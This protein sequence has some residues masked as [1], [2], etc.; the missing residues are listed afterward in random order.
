MQFDSLESFFYMAGHGQYVWLAYG[1]TVAVVAA[2]II[3]PISKRRR[4]VKAI[5]M[6]EMLE[7]E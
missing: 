6:A 4:L 7:Q 2:L 1:I 3:S 5:R